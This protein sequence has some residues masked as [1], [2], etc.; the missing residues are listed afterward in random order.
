[1]SLF[2]KRLWLTALQ[3][4]V[5][6]FVA[7]IVHVQIPDLLYDLGAK[8]PVVVAGP[9]HL[10]AER[11]PGTTFVVIE[12]EADFT[13]AFTYHRYGL[14]YTCFRIAPYG[15]RL[16]VR[17]DGKV[18]DERKKLG[19]FVG[20]L[21]PFDRH[22]FASRI[23]KCFAQNGLEVPEGAFLLLLDDVP[24]LSGWQ[25]GAVLSAC[26]LWL[27]MFYVFFFV[28]RKGPARVPPA[29]LLDAEPPI[30]PHV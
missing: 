9:K 29:A 3:L 8:Q 20:K 4:L 23:R 17:A 2:R 30:P 24:K 5:L 26:V 13:H 7:W 11:L 15:P 21:R 6:A 19:R 14:S 1:M 10:T 16:V 25:V 12:G 28:H 27:A 18:P 22:P